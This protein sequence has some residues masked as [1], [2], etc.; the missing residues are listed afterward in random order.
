MVLTVLLE[1]KMEER[2][3]QCEHE[4][5]MEQLRSL[6]LTRAT[7]VGLAVNHNTSISSG[8]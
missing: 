1:C 8:K 4:Q 5:P 7:Q 6:F 3:S 2:N